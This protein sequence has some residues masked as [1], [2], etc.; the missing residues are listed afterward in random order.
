[1]VQGKVKAGEVE[2]VW[3]YMLDLENDQNPFKEKRLAIEEWRKYSITYIDE[4]DEIIDKANELVRIGVKPKDALHVAS[5]IA[6]EAGYFM[7]TDDKL[8]KKMAT[9]SQ[10]VA[11]NPV[12]LA[13][14]ID[15]RTN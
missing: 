8:V 3:S 10:I 2:L 15:E 5:A 13:A 1:Y 11:I 14:I 4:S 6:G 9:E 12:G 7:T